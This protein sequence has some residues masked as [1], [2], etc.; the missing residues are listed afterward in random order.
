[1]QIS[2]CYIVGENEMGLERSLQSIGPLVQELIIVD[3]T[4]GKDKGIASL[5]E[6]YKGQIYPFAWC[7][8]FSAARNFAIEKAKGDWIVFLDADEYLSKMS[9]ENFNEMINLADRKKSEALL[10]KIF[11]IDEDQENRVLDSFFAPRIFKRKIEIRYVG[12]VHES[13]YDIHGELRTACILEEDLCVYHT[14]YST[15]KLQAKATRNL[16]LLLQEL[17]VEDTPSRLYMAL[18]EAYEG[19]GDAAEALKYAWMDIDNGRQ[20]IT[21]ASR[22][23]RVL[24]RILENQQQI[25]EA[26]IRNVLKKAVQDFPELPEFHAE[27]AQYLASDLRWTEAIAEM[28][29]AFLCMD[30]YALIEPTTFTQEQKNISQKLLLD[31]QQK[32]KRQ[33]EI[34]ISACVIVKNE[35]TEIA[36]WIENMKE[37]SDEQIIVDTGSTD[38]TIEI[39]AAYGIE[40]YHYDWQDHF[41]DAKNF[42]IEQAKG[43]WISFLDADEYFSLETTGNVRAV[44]A[45]AEDLQRP[46]VIMCPE[47]N[48][49][50][51]KN[52]IELGIFMAL[53]LF[54]NVRELRYHGKIHECIQHEKR[55]L[56]VYT[57]KKHLRMYHTGYSSKRVEAKVFRNFEFLQADIA[58][59]GEGPQHYRYLLDC[60]HVLGE[61]DKAVKYGKLHLASKTSSIGMESQVY[62]NLINSMVFLGSDEIEIREYTKEAIKRFPNLPDFYVCM[63]GSMLRQQ[64]FAEA[65]PYLLKALTVYENN[66]EA[67]EDSSNFIFILTEVYSNLAEIVQREGDV[68]QE[69]KYIDLSLQQNKYNEKAFRQMYAHINSLNIDKQKEILSAWYTQEKSDLSF[70]INQIGEFAVADLYFYYVEKLQR[71]YGILSIKS[72]FYRS[73]KEQKNSFS[74]ALGRSVKNIESCLYAAIYSNEWDMCKPLSSILPISMVHCLARYYGQ[75]EKLEAIDDLDGYSTLLGVIAKLNPE[76]ADFWKRLIEISRDFPQE[77]V[78]GFANILYENESFY[79]MQFLLLADDEHIAENTALFMGIAFYHC[80]QYKLS[81][82]YLLQAKMDSKYKIEA[83]SYLAWIQE[84]RKS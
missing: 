5:A 34:K 40:V 66:F 8:D 50:I 70:L 64:K 36:R 46:D 76:K 29:E 23:Y 2:A 9:D 82:R 43:D 6:K 53:R 12:K 20:N 51:D 72:R 63:A 41:G 47:V 11:N 80:G 42:A 18:A 54:R 35:E 60:Y 37:F 14:G 83:D 15:N 52:N 21:Y 68:E 61:H 10:I 56:I 84:K 59:H 19:L 55:E 16:A 49:D 27:Y 44:I 45:F 39:A 77:N 26:E 38:R 81:E 48:I 74:F 25:D 24:L 69:K 58:R 32:S 1:M 28:E 13:L 30:N 22:S 4:N 79:P 67:N 57:E 73:V 65:K 3:T 31:W 78:A 71:E 62:I 7:D 75:L 33:K 17:E